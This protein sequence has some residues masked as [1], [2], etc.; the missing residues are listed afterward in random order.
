MYT[1]KNI[2]MLGM[3]QKCDIIKKIVYYNNILWIQNEIILGFFLFNL[4]ENSTQI[5]LGPLLNQ[6]EPSLKKMK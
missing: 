4:E 1:P 2:C 6:T 3:I 5:F